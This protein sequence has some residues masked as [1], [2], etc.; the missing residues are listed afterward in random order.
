MGANDTNKE[1]VIYPEL[2]YFLTGIFFATH[3][4]LGRYAREKQY[5]DQIERKLRESGIKYQRE[6][7]V[8]LS[9]NRADFLVDGKVLLEIK[10][11]PLV[12]KEDYYQIQRYLQA[13]GMKLGLLVNFRGRYLKPSRIIKIDTPSKA[14]FV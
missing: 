4:E 8:G 5:C 2:S 10:A 7:S 6:C 1:K 9:G 13:S 14:R 12:H 11:K 3:N